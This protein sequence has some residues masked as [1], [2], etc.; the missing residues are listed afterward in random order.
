[1]N[2][3]IAAAALHR[4]LCLPCSTTIRLHQ[5]LNFINAMRKTSPD[6]CVVPKDILRCVKQAPGLLLGLQLGVL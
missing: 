4:L 1:M 6:V 3:E 5:E 2:Q